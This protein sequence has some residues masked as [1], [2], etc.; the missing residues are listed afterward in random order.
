MCVNGGCGQSDGVSGWMGESRGGG[1]GRDSRWEERREA[2]S[3]AS[4]TLISQLSTGKQQSLKVTVTVKMGERDRRG[5]KETG[6]CILAY[7][8]VLAFNR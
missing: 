8:D 3:S 4:Y 2:A 7:L 5:E 6:G 1:G